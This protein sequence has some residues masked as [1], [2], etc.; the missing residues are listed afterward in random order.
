MRLGWASTS[1]RTRG[2]WPARHVPAR[3]AATASGNEL[4]LA[5]GEDDPCAVF[6][7]VAELNPGAL[8]AGFVARPAAAAPALELLP[9]DGRRDLVVLAAC[10]A[11]MD[12]DLLQRWLDHLAF[13]AGDRDVVAAASRWVT[14]APLRAARTPSDI[15]RAARGAPVEA[16]ALAGGDNARRWIDDLRNVTLEID[17]NDL[18]GAG[19]PEGPQVGLRLR[20]A[21]DRKLDGEVSGRDAELAAALADQG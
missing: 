19:I 4:R 2:R 6:E 12:L 20:H 11:A 10:T 9:P 3:S 13:T 18:L 16:V 1:S 5:L 8:P 14:G 17:G 21:L 7:Q 15:A